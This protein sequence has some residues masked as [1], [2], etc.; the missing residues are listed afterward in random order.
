MSKKAFRV[1]SGVDAGGFNVSNVADPRDGNLSDAVNVQYF[2]RENTVQPFDN[3]RSYKQHFAVTHENRLWIAKVDVK[4]GDF[5]QSEWQSLRVDPVWNIVSGT[6]PAG[7]PINSGDYI[8]AYSVNSE[9]TFVLPSAPSVGDTIV[10]KD[11]GMYCHLNKIVVKAPAD[12]IGNGKSEEYFTIPG[13][14][15]TFVYT[16]AG[17]KKWVVHTSVNKIAAKT[18][19]RSDQ[20]NQLASGDQVYRRS[21]TGHITMQLPKYAADGDVIS[22]YDYEGLTPVNGATVQVHP[23]SGH[24][25][26]DGAKTSI[27]TNTSD[28][29]NF[30]FLESSKRWIV[31]DGDNRTRWKAIISDYVAQPMENL[32]VFGGSDI[33][34]TLPK[35]ASNGDCIRLTNLYRNDNTKLK[36]RVDPTTSQFILGSHATLVYPKFNDIPK[37][38]GDY[39]RTT[40]FVFS[41]KE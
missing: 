37:D 12:P 5:K 21:S 22:T 11:E 17:T 35:N 7:T 23:D 10:I 4:A 24:T 16:S 36:F 8:S 13:S 19:A 33:T 34:V 30:V 39:P 1:E 29:G 28:A 32:A 9:L 14:M 26:E 40:E 2:I 31:W 3:T 25:V 6:L 20:P 15:K 41:G 38:V 27:S 18:I